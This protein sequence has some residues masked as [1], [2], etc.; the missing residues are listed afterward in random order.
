M[1]GED[2]GGERAVSGVAHARD[3]YGSIHCQEGGTSEGEGGRGNARIGGA[4][5]Q[6]QR[7]DGG[8]F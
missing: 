7:E 6:R 5:E 8:G 1:G 2:A 4:G 3:E